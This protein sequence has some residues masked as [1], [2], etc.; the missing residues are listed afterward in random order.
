MR[1]L[2][3]SSIYAA[4]FLVYFYTYVLCTNIYKYTYLHVYVNIIVYYS[5]FDL[6]KMMV[7]S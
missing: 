3:D 4:I 2:V 5:D 6:C 7:L 1:V